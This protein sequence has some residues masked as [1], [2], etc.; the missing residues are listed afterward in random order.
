[1][2]YR[3]SASCMY[4]VRTLSLLRYSL[5]GHLVF[6]RGIANEFNLPTKITTPTRLFL[7][8]YPTRKHILFP[9][10]LRT[11]FTSPL[12]PAPSILRGQLRIDPSTG[13]IY[14]H[15]RLPNRSPWPHATSLDTL[16]TAKSR[17]TQILLTGFLSLTS[18]M[19]RMT[20]ARNYPKCLSQHQRR[21]SLVC[22]GEFIFFAFLNLLP[23]SL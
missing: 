13:S 5:R 19:R 15:L 9:S 10:T 14:F 8:Q 1:M 6:P 2:R 20:A 3:R 18:R 7:S 22:K 17:L 4:L 16:I 21:D 12:E 11:L 23:P